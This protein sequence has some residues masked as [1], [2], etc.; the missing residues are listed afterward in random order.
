MMSS[1]EMAARIKLI[2]VYVICIS[3]VFLLIYDCFAVIK[4]GLQGTISWVIWTSSQKYPVIP[5]GAGFLMGHLFF[6][7]PKEDVK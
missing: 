6:Q 7:M 4:G 5:F 1:T 3:F 2:T